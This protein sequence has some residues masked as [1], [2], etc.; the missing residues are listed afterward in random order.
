MSVGMS[1]FRRTDGPERFTQLWAGWTGIY[2][3]GGGD[4]APVS[5]VLACRLD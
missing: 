4:S 5:T 2:G 1:H 3:G